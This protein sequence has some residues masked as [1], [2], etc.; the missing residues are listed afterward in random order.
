MSFCTACSCAAGSLLTGAA[1]TARNETR[2]YCAT[3]GGGTAGSSSMRKG[4]ELS[5]FAVKLQV[6]SASQGCQ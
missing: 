6:C 2:G 1:M 4:G 5:R 3:G